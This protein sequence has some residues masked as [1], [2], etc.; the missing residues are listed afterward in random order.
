[1]RRDFI[2]VAPQGFG[3]SEMARI[4]SRDDKKVVTFGADFISLAKLPEGVDTII[5]DEYSPG[6]HNALINGRVFDTC[7]EN[8][9]HKAVRRPRT[10]ALTND[11]TIRIPKGFVPYAELTNGAIRM[12]EVIA[13]E[14]RD[15]MNDSRIVPLANT[16]G[17][18][19]GIKLY[20]NGFDRD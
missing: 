9:K 19:E 6:M 17:E 5:I 7:N 20:A 15:I 13:E 3:K 12:I 16:F 10:I 14:V 2:I 11:E 18:G 8:Q 1:M 4:L